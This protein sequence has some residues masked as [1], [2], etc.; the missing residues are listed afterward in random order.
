MSQTFTDD[1]YAPGHQATTDLQSFE[2]NFAALKSAFSGTTAPSNL[3]AGMAWLDTTLALLKTRNSVNN[4]WNIVLNVVAAGLTAGDMPYVSAANVLSLLAKG[5]AYQ[6]LNM[7]SGATAPQWMASLQS[8]LT[9]QGDIIYASA[10]NTP[11][12]LAKGTAGQILAM[13]SGATAPEWSG[14]AGYNIAAT[15]RSITGAT[16]TK[17]KEIT[18]NRSGI[19]SASFAISSAWY[20]FGLGKLYINGVAQGVENT[21]IG[22]YAYF[23][24]QLVVKAADAIQLYIKGL[25]IPD[26]AYAKDFTCQGA[27]MTFT[28]VTD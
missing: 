11:V 13:N 10:A 26:T 3:V 1:C 27:G 12:R 15:E 25:N 24:E 6:S 8:I 9:T 21:S 23:G 22:T 7:N 28:V 2:D 4:A 20:G 19:V 5:T 17:I 16:Y 14:N 18:V